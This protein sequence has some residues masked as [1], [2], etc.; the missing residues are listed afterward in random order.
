MLRRSSPDRIHRRAVDEVKRSLSLVIIVAGVLLLPLLLLLLLAHDVVIKKYKANKTIPNTKAKPSSTFTMTAS[1]ALFLLLLC[2]SG[3]PLGRTEAEAFAA[4][5]TSSAIGRPHRLKH[6]T[7]FLVTSLNAPKSN[8]SNRGT[9]FFPQPATTRATTTT[10]LLSDTSDENP[11]GQSPSAAPVADANPTSP[12]TSVSIS[13]SPSSSSDASKALDIAATEEML[14]DPIFW[15]NLLVVNVELSK[16]AIAQNWGFV[17]LA[18]VASS[19]FGLYLL[20]TPI[21]GTEYA[22]ASTMVTLFTMGSVNVMGSAFFNEPGQR[23]VSLCLG[24]AQIVLGWMMGNQPGDAIT[25][26]TGL[27]ATTVFGDGLYQFLL[28]AQNRGALDG[29]WV[30]MLSGL[31]SM[32][33]AAYIV[34]FLDATRF[35]VPGIALGWGLFSSGCARIVASFFGRRYANLNMMVVDDAILSA[36]DDE[37]NALPADALPAA[38]S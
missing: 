12:A 36:I 9:A 29:W 24:F 22:L 15:E 20:S 23:V 1:L 14:A 28:G 6:A 25:L 16:R 7:S 35:F 10:R 38:T 18:G 19:C 11:D 26:M 3:S 31:T 34:K 33:G 2:T 21:I 37:G 30:S 8:Q 4:P 13:Q 5:S 17:L 32:A 27:I